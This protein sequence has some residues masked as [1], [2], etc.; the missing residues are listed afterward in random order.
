MERIFKGKTPEQMAAEIKLGA[1]KSFGSYCLGALAA[2]PAAVLRALNVNLTT[3]Q[4]ATLVTDPALTWLYPEM[5][6]EAVLEG[7][8]N[9]ETAWWQDLI[10]AESSV[11]AKDIRQPSFTLNQSAGPQETQ[12]GESM[13]VTY[14][15]SGSRAV[16]LRKNAEAIGMSYEVT[17][18]ATIDQVKIWNRQYGCNMAAKLNAYAVDRLVNGDQ[19]DLSMNAAVIGVN[20][21]ADGFTWKDFLRVCAV[22]AKLGNPIDFCISD[23][24]EYMDL[25]SMTEFQKMAAGEALTKLNLK[26]P[27]PAALNMFVHSGVGTDKFL[28]G[29]KPK[30]LYKANALPL[31]IETDKDI[32]KQTT[33]VAASETADMVNMLRTARVIVDRTL[34]YAANPFPAWMTPAGVTV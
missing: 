16:T 29:S 14:I 24:A 5:V 20:S 27:V 32:I 7:F 18:F 21:V 3:N 22:M 34:A 25:A 17:A 6:K 15:T 28:F 33:I 11:N 8:E 19:A 12:E 13:Q 9:P 4:V 10:F 31:L 26:T 30:A 2:D 1:W 23:L